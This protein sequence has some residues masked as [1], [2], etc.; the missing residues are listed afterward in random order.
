MKY[1]YKIFIITVFLVMTHTAHAARVFYVS[2]TGNDNNIGDSVNPW[3][4]INISVGKLK[5]GDTLYIKEGVY[6]EAVDLKASGTNGNP[7]TIQG[8]GNV[9]FE[10]KGLSAYDP[11][12][13]TKGHDYLRFRNFRVRNARAG[14]WVNKSH[15]VTIERLKVQYSHF[16]VLMTDASKVVIK[17]SWAKNN[18]NAFRGEG[19]THD[20]F[21]QNVNAYFSKDIYKGYDLNYLN[22]DGFI[23]EKDTSYLTFKNCISGFHWDAGFDIKGKNVILDHVIS[24]RNKNGLKLWGDN[25]LV[26]NALIYSSKSQVRPNGSKVDGVGINVRKG[27]AKIYNSTLSNNESQDL[28]VTPE[29]KL[30]LERSIVFRSLPKGSFLGAYGPFQSHLVIWYHMTAQKPG[31]IPKTQDNMWVDPQFVDWRNNDYH[32]KLASP[33]YISNPPLGAYFPNL[34]GRLNLFILALSR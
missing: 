18:R 6:K 34:K 32:L 13:D 7:I 26:F 20:I 8:L 28:K 19:K 2:G 23:F 15:D 9:I 33:A 14:V 3:H 10:R 25:I 11:V 27:S 4:T 30:S 31:N 5:P 21:I 16:A 29:G 22:G 24:I 17:N 12:F 1:L